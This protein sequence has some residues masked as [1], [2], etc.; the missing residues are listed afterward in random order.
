MLHILAGIALDEQVASGGGCVLKN[1]EAFTA[2]TWRIDCRV[3]GDEGM[4]G[5][6][7]V[8]MMGFNTQSAVPR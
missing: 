8:H 5:E 1:F 7:C 3:T 4:P 6:D 2:M